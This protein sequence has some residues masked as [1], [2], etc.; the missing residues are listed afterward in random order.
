MRKYIT[1][2]DGGTDIELN[3]RATGPSHDP[4]SRE[5]VVV[6]RWAVSVP[7]RPLVK[8]MP[9][10]V[11]MVL[12]AL[13]ETQIVEFSRLITE[14]GEDSTDKHSWSEWEEVARCSRLNFG[15]Q[16]AIMFAQ[17]QRTAQFVQDSFTA[18]AG[19]PLDK[20]MHYKYLAE[21]KRRSRCLDCG[22]KRIEEADG[23]PGEVLFV[24][25]DCKHVVDTEFNEAAVI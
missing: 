5:E 6:T 1:P 8:E 2:Y 12:D 19:M 4:Y 7:N 13:G 14:W 15:L 23:Y 20:A 11:R 17:L 22:S 25:R 24:C 9:Y 16:P 10:R 18:L 3:S 21:S